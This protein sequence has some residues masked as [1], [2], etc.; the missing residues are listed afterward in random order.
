[1]R[2]AFDYRVLSTEAANRGM[3]RYTQQQL[4]ETLKYDEQNE[5]IV[6]CYPYI[7]KDLI[8]PEISASEKVKFIDMPFSEINNLVHNIPLEST[9]TYSSKFQDF[10]YSQKID[11]YHATTP[12]LNPVIPEFTL[13]PYVCTL[14]D[15]IPLIFPKRYLVEQRGL[16]DQYAM[17]LHFLRG[18][19]RI[20]SISN[21]AKEDVISYLGF[22]KNRI[23]IAYPNVEENFYVFSDAQRKSS[24]SKLI[25]KYNLPSK[26]ILSVTGTHYSKNA[27]TLMD[28]YKKITKELRDDIKLVMVLPAKW[29]CDQMIEQYGLSD[30]ILFLYSV[31]DEDLAAL[32]NAALMVVQPS[33]YEGFGYPVA[34]AMKCGTPVI[35]TTSSSLPEVGGDAAILVDPDDVHDFTRNIEFLYNNPVKRQQ[36]R[37]LGIVHVQKFNLEQLGRNTL[38]CYENI[39]TNSIK[40]ES[41]KKRIAV[42]SSFPPINCGVADYTYELVEQLSKIYDISVFVDGEFLPNG[43]LSPFY[44]IHHYTSFEREDKLT[45]FIAVIYQMGSTLNQHFMFDMIEKKKGIIV[46]H[47]LLMGLG[48][49]SIYKIR[50]EPNKFKHKILEVEG[51]NVSK[52]FSALIKSAK[53]D[54]IPKLDLFFR[55]NLMLKW[56]INNSHAQIVHMQSVKDEIESLYNGSQVSVVDMGV[57]DPLKNRSIKNKGFL[58]LKYKIAPSTLV[59]GIFGSVVPIKRIESSLKALSHVVKI[60]ND[61]IMM[62]V[63]DHPIGHYSAHLSKMVEN[64]GLN[65]HVRFTGR[66]SREDFDNLFLTSDVVL[67]LRHPTF[68]GMSAI[69]IR[70]LAAGKPVIISDVPEWLNFSSEFCWRISTGEDEEG[71]LIE[72]LTQIIT[73]PE[74]IKN[75]SLKAREY[76]KTRGLLSHMADQ[77]SRVIEN[78]IEHKS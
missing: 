14:Y 71:Q 38:N 58:R 6:L 55:R 22:D 35:T 53:D 24:I 31:S 45:P 65:Q 15:L 5:Y 30:N 16:S 7:K 8:F 50:N 64:L 72:L 52:E 54:L 17:S 59:I 26:F 60:K 66:S 76:F 63:G 12:F 51:E 36:M 4:R 18:S 13:C 48:F 34:E 27:S 39:F 3:G 62:I 70:A 19:S 2:I 57:Q 9:L 69:I 44:Q 20:I 73:N 11:L 42:F 21:S 56:L 10:L 61:V 33:R 46:F 49:Y 43:F 23:D 67:N 40:M 41:I 1:M 25:A 78:V 77:Y 74:I 37:D 47:D 29:V 75:A 68:K 32:Y 28:S